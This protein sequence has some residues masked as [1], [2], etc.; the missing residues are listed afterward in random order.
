MKTFSVYR[1]RKGMF[2]A[3]K[4]GWSW[5][6]FFFGWIWALV[7]GLP[8]LAFGLL[9]SI[10]L[11][12]I[13]F[14]GVGAPNG[15]LGFFVLAIAFW[16]GSRGNKLY[17]NKIRRKRHECIDTFDAYSAS[18]AIQQV[19]NRQSQ[20]S[21]P[22]L[23]EA[24]NIGTRHDNMQK[25]SAF[26]LA[27]NSRSRVEPHLL[28]S[29]QHENDA[30]QALLSLD[31]IHQAQDTGKL[32][33]TKPIVFG[34]YGDAE[35]SF[36]AVLCGKALAL[37]QWQNA[38]AIFEKHGGIL[39]SEEKPTKTDDSVSQKKEDVALDQVKFKSEQSKPGAFGTMNTYVVYTA[40][41]SA[42]AQA[43]LE[44]QKVTENFYYIVVET[45]EGNY[46]RD[47]EGIYQE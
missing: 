8:G 14:V 31:Y 10:F 9:I 26:W 45:P 20:G 33:C 1:D 15:V 6:A 2:E 17:E 3:V 16:V 32:I 42:T 13:L 18:E 4:Q 34:V 35:A 24:D 22:K 43:F 21:E 27:Y 19:R 29:F 23:T 25:A 12:T 46:G 28:Y 7:K 38:K 40:P 39:K 44:E 37:E 41:N 11:L 47:L 30:R 5:P 36:E